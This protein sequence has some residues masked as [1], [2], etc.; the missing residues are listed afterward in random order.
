MMTFWKN[1][2]RPDWSYLSHY[3]EQ[4]EEVL[5]F[6]VLQGFQEAGTEYLVGM[7]YKIKPENTVLWERDKRWHRQHLVMDG[8]HPGQEPTGRTRGMGQVT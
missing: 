6:T 4:P 2:K 3:R 5:Y 1:W 7:S 8:F